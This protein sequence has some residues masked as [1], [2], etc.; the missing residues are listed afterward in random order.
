[1]A[2]TTFQSG[3][4]QVGS[5]GRR[6]PGWWGVIMLVLTEGALFAFLLFC[7]Y[8]FAVQYGREWLPI[9]LPKFKLSGPNTV[10]LLLSSVAVW[11]GERGVKRGSRATLSVGLL[12][13]ILLGALFVGIQVKEWSDKPFTISSDSYGSVYFTVTGFH[14]AH[15]VGGLL[16]LLAM[17]AWSLLGYFDDKRHAAVTIGALYWHFVD[18]VW[19]TIFFTF[20]VTPYLT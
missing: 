6:A 1:M 8:Y 9:E 17:F 4:L 12:V 20:Y 19:L 5:V 16:A 10:I 15:V 18:A 3:R 7:Y 11:F 13:G 14:M 2:D